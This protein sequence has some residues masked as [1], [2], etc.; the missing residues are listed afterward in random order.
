MATPTRKRRKKIVEWLQSL[1]DD[2]VI[3]SSVSIS[4]INRGIALL[5]ARNPRAAEIL[6]QALEG[7]V[8]SYED[9]VI[10]P[11][12]A[13]WQSFAKLSAQPELRHLCRGKN[14]KDQPRTGADIFLAVQANTIASAVATL[15]ARDFVTID[16][17]MPIVGGI[18]DPVSGIWV[19]QQDSA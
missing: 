2:S 6:K 15:N 14:E 3:L 13:E 19:R 12:H 17:Y 8:S 18:I 11:S 9:A 10:T 5:E 1:G 16:R 7:I 4:E